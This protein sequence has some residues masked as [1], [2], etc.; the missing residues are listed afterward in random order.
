MILRGGIFFQEWKVT[1]CGGPFC[2]W[3]YFAFLLW[4]C[5]WFHAIS[6]SLIT[7]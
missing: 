7:L 6:F 1:Q 3:L 5:W 2:P 4:K